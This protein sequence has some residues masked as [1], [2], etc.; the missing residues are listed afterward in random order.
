MPMPCKLSVITPVFNGVRFIECCIRSV[1]EQNCAEAEHIIIDGG[2]TDGTVEVIRRYVEEYAHIRWVS[3]KD[4][5]QSEAMNKGIRMA[6]GE[7]IS[8]LNADDYYEP[9]ALCEAVAMFS[10]LAEPTLLV[11]N[12]NIWDDV[13]NLLGVCRPRTVSLLNLLMQRYSSAFPMNPSGYFYHKSLHDKIG[14]YDIDDHFGMDVNFIFRALQTAQVKYVDR[15]WGNMR[16]FADTK[17]FRDV[18]SGQNRIR[19][20]KITDFYRKQAPFHYR[21]YSS[22]YVNLVKIYKFCLKLAGV[23]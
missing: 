18:A 8:I 2:S 14:P 16:Y 21:V 19:V 11:G 20:G 15:L 4:S 7:I 10:D 1:I 17:T 23:K 22:T 12:C 13:D 9:G 5:G 6:S 3:E